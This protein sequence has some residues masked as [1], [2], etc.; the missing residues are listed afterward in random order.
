[1]K[2][3]DPLNCFLHQDSACVYRMSNKLAP[4]SQ[5][6]A[7]EYRLHDV[8]SP[9]NKV[10]MEA[11]G[12]DRGRFYRAAGILRVRNK[13]SDSSWGVGESH[14]VKK[15]GMVSL[16]TESII[17]AKRSRNEG[18]E[19]A[20][21]EAMATFLDMDKKVSSKANEPPVNKVKFRDRFRRGEKGEEMLEKKM[22]AGSILQEEDS[23]VKETSC[24]NSSKT[25][26]IR[27]ASQFLSKVG[28]E[29]DETSA[30]NIIRRAESLIADSSLHV[31]LL[32]SAVS[33][34]HVRN[35][36]GGQSDDEFHRCGNEN[37]PYQCI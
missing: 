13:I 30:Q 1:M 8:R 21:R 14:D 22:N 27:N 32:R 23:V 26:A 5:V 19:D 16:K 36:L 2:F 24:D 11:L 3:S 28:R 29:R 15:V 6:A 25:V 10:V 12:C 4:T 37:V 20:I 17:A 9:Y 35:Y 34:L 18:Q 7:S 33:L 31:R